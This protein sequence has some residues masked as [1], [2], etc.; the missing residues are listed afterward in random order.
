MNFNHD[1]KIDVTKNCRV[2]EMYLHTTTSQ[3][4]YIK[5]INKSMIHVDLNQK[6]LNE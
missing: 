1:Y 3:K 2:I 6:I 5:K 4:G